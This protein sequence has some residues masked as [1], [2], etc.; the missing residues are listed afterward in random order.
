M[1]TGDSRPTPLDAAISR[2]RRFPAGTG[3]PSRC[4]RRLRRLAGS[5]CSFSFVANSARDS[6]FPPL[7]RIPDQPRAPFRRS[8]DG[9]VF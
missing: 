2:G 3:V 5:L 1:R 9:I 4:P 8:I 6:L 7:I